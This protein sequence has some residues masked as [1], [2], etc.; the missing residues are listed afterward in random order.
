MHEIVIG[1]KLSDV[2]SFFVTPNLA[3]NPQLQPIIHC[4][5]KVLRDTATPGREQLVINE[6]HIGDRCKTLVNLPGRRDVVL[7]SVIVIVVRVLGTDMRE[8][9]D[10]E[11]SI[12]QI[13]TKSSLESDRC[14]VITDHVEATIEPEIQIDQ[15]RR[16]PNSETTKMG[17]RDAEVVDVAFRV[18]NV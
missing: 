5:G 2:E 13:Q 3:A 18:K 8:G 12:E 15:W 14:V 11:I 4:I 10:R 1:A 17:Y 16:M 6:V 9:Q 7:K